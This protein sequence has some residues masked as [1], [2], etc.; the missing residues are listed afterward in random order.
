MTA[1][2]ARAL[3]PAHGVHVDAHRAERDLAALHALAAWARRFSPLVAV[4][5]P[6][7]LYLDVTG[8]AHLFGGEQTMARRVVEAVRRLGISARA[9]I[10]P[11]CGCARAVARFADR[12][13]SIVP[14]GRQRAALA[15]LPVRALD[16]DDDTDAALRDIGVE[17]IG[18]LLDL[19]RSELPARFGC[20]LLLRLDRALGDAIETIEPVRPAAAPQT[21]RV[22]G[23]PTLRLESV[24]A[25]VRAALE[26]LC[27]ALA[28][29]QRGVRTLLVELTRCHGAPL[30]L[31]ITLSRTSSDVRH[32]WSLLR[33]RLERVNLGFGVERVRLIAARTGRV[34]YEQTGLASARHGAW[35]ADDGG[36]GATL[37]RSETRRRIGE[38]VDALVNRLGASRVTRV[39][40]VASHVPERAFRRVPLTSPGPPTTPGHLATVPDRP[41]MLLAR[42]EPAHV[43][44]LTPD[45]PLL[46]MTWRG[47]DEGIVRCCGPERIEREW[48]RD[49]VAAAAR[50]WFR[51]QDDR[52][53]WLWVFR[54][55]NSGRWFVHGLWA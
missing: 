42:P 29:R 21:V 31:T 18:Q 37:S 55:V 51:V 38:L 41:S 34:R 32:L 28:G 9:A 3:L 49:P 20:D 12:G 25:A 26:D 15:P 8:C 2:H 22:F 1:A 40:L 50:D 24:E 13:V 47:R 46:R 53:R 48:W 35:M 19:P 44:A 14:A 54:E 7:G 23:G 17:R 4:D 16:L 6:D 27:R 45:G 39:E 36:D 10:A 11:T 33:P 30:Q 5:P 52:G 43:L